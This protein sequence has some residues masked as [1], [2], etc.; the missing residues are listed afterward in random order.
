VSEGGDVYVAKLNNSVTRLDLASYRV[1]ATLSGPSI[2]EDVA[3]DAR[4]SKAY[5]AGLQGPLT[6]IDVSTNSV[7]GVIGVGTVTGSVHAVARGSGR[8]GSLSGC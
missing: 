5:V 8:Q 7:S 3:F 1:V 4:G 2:A 6:I